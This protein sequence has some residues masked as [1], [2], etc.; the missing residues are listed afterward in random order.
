MRRA[1]PVLALLAALLVPAAR[2]GEGLEI[3]PFVG[4]RFGGS[5]DAYTGERYNLDSAS[6]YGLGVDIPLGDGTSMLELFWSRQDTE[7]R[8]GGIFEEASRFDLGIETYQV[9]VVYELDEERIRPFVMAGL[10]ATR[11]KID[12][13]SVSDSTVFALSAGGGAKFFFGD[14]LGIRLDGRIYAPFV[15]GSAGVACGGGGGGGGCFLSF[16]GNVLWQIEFGAGLVV[17]F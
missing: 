1:L 14:H 9:G 2:A 11:F 5:L 3:T 15:G 16:S 12:R 10:G 6:S 13:G 4:Y 8:T 7:V 17:A